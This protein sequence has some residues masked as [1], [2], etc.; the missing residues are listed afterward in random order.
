MTELEIDAFLTV[1]QAGSISKAAEQL[2]VSQPALSRRLKTLENELGYSLLERKK[3]ARILTLTV[4]GA[5]FLPI[6]EQWRSLWHESKLVLGQTNRPLLRAGAVDSINTYTMPHVYLHLMEDKP[7]IQLK[8]VGN[9][10]LEGYRLIEM[11]ALDISFVA[12][13]MYARQVSVTPIFKE[14][15]WLVGADNFG[16]N[17]VIHPTQLD[18]HQEL[19]VDWNREF[20]RWH[21][22]WFTSG[23]QPK[24]FVTQMAFLEEM[25]ANHRG[26]AIVPASAAWHLQNR[27]NLN[28]RKL[29]VPPA[30]RIVYCI[31]ALNRAYNPMI[32]CL[33][34]Y[35]NDYISGIS[36]MTPLHKNPVPNI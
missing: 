13:P 4:A 1:V 24:I 33:L 12:Y 17:M 6:A 35:L 31:R 28:V 11:G 29:T 7:E 22:S 3:G 14:E 27:Y 20:V 36:G 21:E 9:G 25:L 23:S 2:F 34:V 10:S 8:I 26:W 15:M 30:D 5:A 18:I 32:D 19:Y 16:D